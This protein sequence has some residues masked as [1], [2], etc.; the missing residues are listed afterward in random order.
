MMLNSQSQSR[1]ISPLSRSSQQQQQQQPMPY[2]SSY[3]GNLFFQWM[4][5]QMMMQ[6]AAAQMPY[7]GFSPADFFNQFYGQYHHQQHQQPPPVAAEPGVRH[8]TLVKAGGTFGLSVTMAK[9]EG[10]LPAVL[11]SA[12]ATGSPAYQQGVQPGDELLE[13]EGEKVSNM[14]LHQLGMAIRNQTKIRLSIRA[15]HKTDPAV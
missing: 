9:R 12:V 4:T 5:G 11:V 10:D 13:L 14:T 7:A 8:I 6:A 15:K 1:P 2:S 3:P